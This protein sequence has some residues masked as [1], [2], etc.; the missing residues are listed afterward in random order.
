MFGRGV[1]YARGVVV[2]AATCF[3][4]RRPTFLRVLLLASSGRGRCGRAYPGSST[5]VVAATLMSGSV[6]DARLAATVIGGTV[7]GARVT[8]GALTGGTVTGGAVAGGGL[9]GGTVIGGMVTGGSVLGGG[10]IEG[11][12]AATGV[13]TCGCGGVVTTAGSVVVVSAELDVGS[14]GT[15]WMSVSGQRSQGQSSP[16]LGRRG[17]RGSAPAVRRGAR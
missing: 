3:V 12:T 14:I 13:V 1:R 7:T 17:R 5:R 9:T 2:L 10:G 15:L 8:G 11:G 16:S 4:D 6:V